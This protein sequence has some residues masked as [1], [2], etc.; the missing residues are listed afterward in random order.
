[1][2][3]N[4]KIHVKKPEKN[5]HDLIVNI[6]DNFKPFFKIYFAGKNIDFYLTIN[7]SKNYIF[8]GPNWN[9]FSMTLTID[10]ETFYVPLKVLDISYKSKFYFMLLSEP[11]RIFS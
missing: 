4:G 9:Y 6:S 3:H 11:K 7:V 1:M 2:A 10:P 8:C 5:L